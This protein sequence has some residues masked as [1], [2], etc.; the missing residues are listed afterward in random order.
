MYLLFFI[1]LPKTFLSTWY[2]S[3]QNNN[4]Y[5]LKGVTTVSTKIRTFFKIYH[6][7]DYE[8]PIKL[9]LLRPKCKKYN[10]LV[11]IIINRC[12]QKV[13]TNNMFGNVKGTK[14]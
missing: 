13:F 3:A 9:K 1:K 7:H 10:I 4:K 14:Q 11:C 6:H 5:L 2:E 8:D 12:S